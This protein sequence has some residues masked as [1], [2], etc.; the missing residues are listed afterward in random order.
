MDSEFPY[1]D[2]RDDIVV[3]LYYSFKKQEIMPDEI[4]DY[5]EKHGLTVKDEK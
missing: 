2:K 3:A 4:T 1:P 5:I